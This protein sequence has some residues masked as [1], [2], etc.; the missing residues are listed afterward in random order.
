VKIHQ[1]HFALIP[2]DAISS[3]M[4]EI[5][6]RLRARGLETSI[7]AGEIAPELADRARHEDEYLA[8][9]RASDGV[10]IYHYGLYDSPG[11]RYFQASRGRKVLIYHNITP[12]HY[13]RG[14]SREMELL[15][16][17]GQRTLPALAECDLALGASEFN[18]RQL[19][20]AGFDETRTGVL[21]IFL[22]QA[23]FEALPTNRPLLDQLQRGS[24]TNF[25]TVG[26]VAPNKA[27]EDG[28]RIFAVYHRA[29]N[30]NSRLVIVGSRYLCSYDAA[31]DA[32]ITDLGLGK[33][34][35]FTGLV[36]DADLK[37]YYQAA[38]LYL[39][40]SHHEGFCVPLLESMHFGVPIL[41]RKA[42][43][44]PETLGD[45]GVLFTRLG[46]EEVAEMACLLLDDEV[47]R[48][49]VIA[50]Q[51]ERLADF[52]PARIEA[53]LWAVLG[54]LGISPGSTVAGEG[55]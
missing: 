24:T 29:I 1:M 10:L 21:P 34:V 51:R 6:D 33:A 47:L 36:S 16:E 3:H 32:L 22:A 44:V 20:E 25:V 4:L 55:D 18:R 5:D 39:H 43:A 46:Y 14:W 28:I 27:I 8:Y 13:F 45:A 37:T 9:L 52:A 26:R 35:L 49:R 17:V 41:A 54:R 11:V 40:A 53:R 15:C 7:F 42:G 12:A 38:D 2:G 48:A 19:V 30:P 31:L 50:R 23:R